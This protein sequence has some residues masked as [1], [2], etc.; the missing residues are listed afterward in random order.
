VREG[1][2]IL[3]LLEGKKDM[4]LLANT[5]ERGKHFDSFNTG[6]THSF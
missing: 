5:M 4:T 6:T 3:D 2:S 1:I